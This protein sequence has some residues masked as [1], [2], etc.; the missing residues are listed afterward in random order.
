MRAKLTRK[1]REAYKNLLC[2]FPKNEGIIWRDKED[3]CA[4]WVFFA[5]GD[6]AQ[7]GLG[8]RPQGAFCHLLGYRDAETKTNKKMHGYVIEFTFL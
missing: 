6:L 5:S 8:Q 4:F 2:L 3:L 7:A 1:V